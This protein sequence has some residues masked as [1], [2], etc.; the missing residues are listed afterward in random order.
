[1]QTQCIDITERGVLGIRTMRQPTHRVKIRHLHGGQHALHHTLCK[2]TLA[3]GAPGLGEFGRIEVAMGIDPGR[4]GPENTTAHQTGA[5]GPVANPP[6][7]KYS[8]TML[9]CRNV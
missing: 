9:P 5:L 8:R 1:M 4:H 2:G 3:H 7:G 6:R